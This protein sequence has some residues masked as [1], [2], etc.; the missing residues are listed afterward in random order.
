MNDEVT[1]GSGEEMIHMTPDELRVA[2][3]AYLDHGPDFI[4]Y[5]ATHHFNYPAPIAFSPRA[6]RVI[7]EETHRRGLVAETH[8]TSLEGLPPLGPRGDRS[9]PAP[10]QRREPHDH[11]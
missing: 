2:I 3:N 8:A 5:G 1:L 9:H 10:R 7:V 4:K 6:Q 11:R